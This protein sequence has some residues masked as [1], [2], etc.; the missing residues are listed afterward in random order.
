MNEIYILVV[1]EIKL[2]KDMF[3]QMEPIGVYDDLEMALN[4]VD[5]LEEYSEENKTYMYDISQ[6]KLN[7][8]PVLLKLLKKEREKLDQAVSKA[9]ITLMKEGKVDQLIG[10]DGQFYYTLTELGKATNKN[11][12]ENIKKLFRKKKDK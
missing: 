1:L 5:E 8:P 12:S 7:D 10:E 6:F 2:G 4:F 11:L 9:L 3:S